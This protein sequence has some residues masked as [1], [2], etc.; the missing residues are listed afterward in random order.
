MS[1]CAVPYSVM[2]MQQVI[3]VQ[4]RASHVLDRK[5]QLAR[6]LTVTGL[7]LCCAVDKYINSFLSYY[8]IRLLKMPSMIAKLQETS[9]PLWMVFHIKP[10]YVL[11]LLSLFSSHWI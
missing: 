6:M 11:V 10:F 1:G 2:T 3:S 8:F 4:Y 5:V 7:R 9:V